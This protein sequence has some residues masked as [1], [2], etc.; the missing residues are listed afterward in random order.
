MELW[1]IWAAMAINVALMC[2]LSR[3]LAN[4]LEAI[5]RYMKANNKRHHEH[6]ARLTSISD[7]IAALKLNYAAQANIPEDVP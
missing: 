1:P 6:D 7:D 2:L 4:M 3:D 5:D